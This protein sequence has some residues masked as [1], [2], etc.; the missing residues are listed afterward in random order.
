MTK[1]AVPRVRREHSICVRGFLAPGE[2][3]FDEGRSLALWYPAQFVPLKKPQPFLIED[4]PAWERFVSQFGDFYRHQPFADA[5]R[6]T[7][8]STILM[9]GNATCWSS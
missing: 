6:R 3:G 5:V 7:A 8:G 9:R 4:A 2:M 1:A